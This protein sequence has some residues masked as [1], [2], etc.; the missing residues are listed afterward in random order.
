MYCIVL[1]VLL[2]SVKQAICQQTFANHD[3]WTHSACQPT[4]LS[5]WQCTP[6]T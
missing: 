2:Y 5:L 6:C 4:A 1:P 3:A